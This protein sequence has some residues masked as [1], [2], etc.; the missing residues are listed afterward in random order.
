MS[1]APMTTS[2]SATDSW[3]WSVE[4]ISRRDA[5]REDLLEV[6]HAVDRALEDRHLRTEAERDHAA[7]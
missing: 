2:A 3:I 5:A 1:T 6:A 7:L 4:D